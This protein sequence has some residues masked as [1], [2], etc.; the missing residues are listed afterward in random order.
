MAVRSIGVLQLLEGSEQD[1]KLIA[2]APGSPMASALS[3]DDLQR[4]FPGVLDIL[5]LWFSHY[6]GHG[7]T[8]VSGTAGPGRA[9]ATLDMAMESHSLRSRN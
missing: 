4:D 1:D 6:K 8:Q 9:Q 5:S 7:V 3:I 2:I